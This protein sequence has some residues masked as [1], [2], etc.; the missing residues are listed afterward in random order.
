VTDAP[1]DATQLDE[2]RSGYAFEGGVLKL[3]AALVKPG[4]RL[5]YAVCSLL[6]EEGAAQTA[7][8]LAAHPGWT[9][10]PAPVAAGRPRGDG[11]LL[12]PAH[13][14]TDGFFIAG[15]CRPC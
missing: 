14:R 3:G 2:I 1:A 13:D 15:L 6:E 11:L 8:F 12:T 9:A 7:A 5:V 4:G 10:D